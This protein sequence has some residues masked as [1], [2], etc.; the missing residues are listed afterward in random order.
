VRTNRPVGE[1]EKL[2]SLSRQAGV[3]GGVLP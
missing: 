1:A 3:E 2:C